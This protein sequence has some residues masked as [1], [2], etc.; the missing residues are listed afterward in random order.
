LFKVE[1]PWFSRCS[2]SLLFVPTPFRWVEVFGEFFKCGN[3][4]GRGSDWLGCVWE[5]ALSGWRVLEVLLRR[6][7]LSGW[8]KASR[9]LVIKVEGEGRR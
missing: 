2:S 4:S 6:S 8:D 9:L 5:V 3:C 1:G 7:Q